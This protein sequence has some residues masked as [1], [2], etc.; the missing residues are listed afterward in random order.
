MIRLI[1]A[2]LLFA[3]VDLPPEAQAQQQ[4]PSSQQTPGQQTPPEVFFS[5]SELLVET[6]RGATHRFTVELATSPEQQRR[7]LM[8]RDH[9]PQNQGMLFIFETPRP[10][11][12]W[13]RN[14]RISLDM[15]FL[16]TQGRVVNIARRTTPM[17]DTA[18]RSAGPAKAVLEI[19]AGLSDLL[20]IAPGD[21]VIHSRLGG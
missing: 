11:S 3:V 20:G 12:F 16:D 18:Y 15:L 19:N 10:L 9:L 4:I 21:Q 5:R 2:L 6:S 13:M 1:S 14:T 8:F 17:S 7:G